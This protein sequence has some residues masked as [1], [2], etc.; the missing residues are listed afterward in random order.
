MERTELSVP[1]VGGSNVVVFPPPVPLT[2]FLLGVAPERVA[3]L[4][5]FVADPLL[6]AVR[7]A[8]AVVPSPAPRGSRGW[9]RR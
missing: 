2:G 7:S 3:P 8:G 4:A 6:L 9:S 1:D 5:R